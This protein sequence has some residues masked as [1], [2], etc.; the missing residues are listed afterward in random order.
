MGLYKLSASLWHN[1]HWHDRAHCQNR[2]WH[3]E[4]LS[5]H[6]GHKHDAG[7]FLIWQLAS[8]CYIH[9]TEIKIFNRGKNHKQEQTSK[10][11][12]L[13][14]HLQKSIHVHVYELNYWVQRYEVTMTLLKEPLT[15]RSPLI[16]RSKC[17]MYNKHFFTVIYMYSIG[18]FCFLWFREWDNLNLIPI[19]ILWQ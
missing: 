16:N 18:Q 3:N 9:M 19:F 1:R 10:H 15:I 5:I 17:Y 2:F 8:T 13:H 4:M 14:V 11:T 7:L 12:Y 6:N